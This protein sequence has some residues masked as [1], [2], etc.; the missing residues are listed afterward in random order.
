MNRVQL[1]YMFLGCNYQEFQQCRWRRQWH[2][3]GGVV[4]WGLELRLEQGTP[5]AEKKLLNGSK[6]KKPVEES[7][8]SPVL[9]EIGFFYWGKT[10]FF[11]KTRFHWDLVASLLC[12]LKQFPF[13]IE[14]AY[15]P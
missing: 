4:E 11:M 3:G 12:F 14:R 13:P 1:Q 7:K 9:Q 10:V 15:A 5:T 8:A 6:A 2:G